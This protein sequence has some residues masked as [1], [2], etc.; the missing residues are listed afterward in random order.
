M[1]IQGFLKIDDI[2]GESQRA[3]HEEEI[4]VHGLRWGAELPTQ[5]SRTRGRTRARAQVDQLEVRKFYDASSP[6]LLL[7]CMQGRAYPE[8][9]LAVRKDSGDAHLDYL[10]ITMTNVVVVD[11]EMTDRDIPDNDLIEERIALSFEKVNV[12]YTV[13]ADDH[14]AGDEHEIEYDIAAGV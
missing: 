14:S 2:A 8:M 6:Y 1:T 13:Q 9:T 11:V 5:S 3:E 12:K 4:D 7:G 10:V